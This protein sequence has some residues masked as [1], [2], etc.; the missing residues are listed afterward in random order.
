MTMIT[1]PIDNLPAS[2]EHLHHRKTDQDHAGQDAEIS[3]ASAQDVGTAY[4]D[5]G[6]GRQ[7]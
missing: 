6:N 7:H 2:L 1:A 5:R 4:D 3:P